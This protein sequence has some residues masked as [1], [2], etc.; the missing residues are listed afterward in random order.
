M[1]LSLSVC[2]CLLLVGCSSLSYQRNEASGE[3]VSFSASSLFTRKAVKD[4]EFETGTNS[5]R[6]LRLR[7]YNDNQ[8]EL[9]QSAI[10]AALAAYIRQQPP[11]VVTNIVK[12]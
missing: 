1:R 9:M 2:A 3:K 4:L 5:T 10:E 12:P 11:I 6:R 7:G 8:V